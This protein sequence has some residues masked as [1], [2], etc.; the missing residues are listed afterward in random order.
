MNISASQS[1]LTS[2]EI[3]SLSFSLSFNGDRI[4]LAFVSSLVSLS[5][6]SLREELFAKEKSNFAN[7]GGKF[8]IFPS[9]RYE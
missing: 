5:L 1:K 7:G 4:W 6:Y 9:V 2:R 3:I 8:L